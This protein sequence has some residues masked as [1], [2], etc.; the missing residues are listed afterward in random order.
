MKYFTY[1]KM[2]P[3]NLV[4]SSY[5]SSRYRVT[6]P[7]CPEGFIFHD[8]EAPLEVESLLLPL[9]KLRKLFENAREAVVF[10]INENT[11]VAS[12]ST[13]AIPKPV[14]VTIRSKQWSI[15][16]QSALYPQTRD[17][18]GWYIPSV[19]DQSQPIVAF[20]IG[21]MY[22][23]CLQLQ[24]LMGSCPCPH[25]DSG[26]CLTE[27]VLPTFNGRVTLDDLNANYYIAFDDRVKALLTREFKQAGLFEYVSPGLTTEHDF[28]KG[29]RPWDDIDF[30][31]VPER[32]KVFKDRGKDRRQTTTHVKAA[33]TTCV[34]AYKRVT[35]KGSAVTPCGSTDRCTGSVSSDEAE[36]LVQHVGTRDRIENHSEFS[37]EQVQ[38]L[39]QLIGKTYHSKVITPTRRTEIELTGFKYKHTSSGKYSYVFTVHSAKGDRERHCSFKSYEELLTGIP[40]IAS[41]VASVASNK[42][43]SKQILW[44]YVLQL[45]VLQIRIG[46]GGSANLRKIKL[47]ETTAD[48]G[49]TAEYASSRAKYYRDYLVKDN[50]PH[51]WVAPYIVD[52][53]LRARAKLDD[54]GL[55]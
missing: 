33:C 50:F 19:V 8:S 27:N 38:T 18:P 37:A 35:K 28:Y 4:P 30:S 40:Q 46:W 13:A 9:F 34:F 20:D 2:S 10:R 25:K 12:Y 45:R 17:L 49:L 22:D 52:H 47:R 1:C 15:P 16:D 26:V 24:R 51:A 23:S 55:V 36:T 53:P 48:F 3:A 6:L 11:L 7:S 43:F 14:T 44:A 31:R 42:P 5:R 39:L 32:R 54:L 29:L 21:N 41:D